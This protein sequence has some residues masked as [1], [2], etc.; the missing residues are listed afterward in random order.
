MWNGF[1]GVLWV[2]K[3]L[4][5]D[6]R[7]S[8]SHLWKHFKHPKF[9]LKIMLLPWKLDFAWKNAVFLPSRKLIEPSVWV[10]RSN[11]CIERHF[12]SISEASRARFLI[13]SLL[14]EEINFFFSQV[15][16]YSKIG[17]KIHI[18]NVKNDFVGW[19]NSIFSN[20]FKMVPYEVVWV[21]GC[22]LGLGTS[23]SW[24]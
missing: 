7:P 4:F 10:L 11:H 8:R 13:S 1:G 21:W 2:S 17:F 14:S 12:G 3:H 23:F 22:A 6:P 20:S 16:K 15:S 18:S 5:H 24:S 9:D 19:K